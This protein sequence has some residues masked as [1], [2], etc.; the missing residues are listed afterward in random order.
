[1]RLSTRARYALHVMILVARLGKGEQPLSLAKVAERTRL[2]YRYLEKLVASLKK[3]SLLQP[4]WGRGGG[5]L[6]AR[7]S[8]EIRIGEIVEAG[9]GPINVVQCARR[10]ESCLKSDFCE[11]RLLY[12]LINQ[13]IVQ[14]LYEYSL[15]D[16]AT[17]NWQE[18]IEAQLALDG[19]AGGNPD[20]WGTSAN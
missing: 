10:P 16:I 14:T 8:E 4:V 19:E 6:L 2:S 7:P 5:Y 15:A 3:A 9:A 11:C 17:G 20:V 1:M 13:R 12:A 18:K